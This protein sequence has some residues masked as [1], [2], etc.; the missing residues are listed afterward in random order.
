ML[1]KDAG[2]VLIFSTQ[3]PVNGLGKIKKRDDFKLYGT[4]KEKTLFV[5]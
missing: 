1:F 3:A 2:R 5:P 4:E